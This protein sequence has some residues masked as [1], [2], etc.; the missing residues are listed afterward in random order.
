MVADVAPLYEACR[1]RK[2]VDLT[3]YTKRDGTHVSHTVGINEIDTANG[4]LWGWD[5]NENLHIR[6]FIMNDINAFQVLDQ[7]Y[8]SSQFPIKIDGVEV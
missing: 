3:D 2:V 1:A 7:D 6:K 4:L 5:V 8:V